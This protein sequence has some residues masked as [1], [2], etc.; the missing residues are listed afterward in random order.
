MNSEVGNDALSKGKY[1]RLAEQLCK[2]V[3]SFD[4]VTDKL[5]YLKSIAYM[6]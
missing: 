6:Q 5:K 1:V 4:D 2:R 3:E